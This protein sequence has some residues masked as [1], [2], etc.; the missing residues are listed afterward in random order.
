MPTSSSPQPRLFT[1]ALEWVSSQ[2]SSRDS[3]HVAKQQVSCTRV[4]RFSVE[5]KKNSKI[6]AIYSK[7][8]FFGSI[9]NGLKSRRKDR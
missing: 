3:R 7:I 2:V 1:H 6:R 8:L 4:V 5:Q 9:V